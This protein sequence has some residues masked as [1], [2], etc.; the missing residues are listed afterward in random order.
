MNQT[1]LYRDPKHDPL[2]DLLCGRHTKGGTTK[3][4]FP[5]I[6]VWKEV[7]HREELWSK[8]SERWLA[9]KLEAMEGG[10]AKG[11]TDRDWA[12]ELTKIRKADALALKIRPSLQDS[13]KEW[14]RKTTLERD[15]SPLSV[16]QR[17]QLSRF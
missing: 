12:N 1:E 9:N 8:D 3:Y 15:R 6:T 7:H 17:V 13:I 5:P 16:P 14:W 11:R 2:C 10:R 4:F